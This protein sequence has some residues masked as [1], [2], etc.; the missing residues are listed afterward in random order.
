[1]L[2]PESTLLMPFEE[3]PGLLEL[4]VLKLRMRTPDTVTSCAFPRFTPVETLV[5]IYPPV[6][7]PSEIRLVVLKKSMPFNPLL[8]QAGVI[9]NLLIPA[10]EENAMQ[11][12]L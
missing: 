2:F 8:S 10:V 1:M 11:S 7:E 12:E 3:M 9:V 6:I 5:S 4:L